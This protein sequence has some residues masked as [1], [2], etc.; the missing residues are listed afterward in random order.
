[1]L[2]LVLAVLATPQFYGPSALQPY[3]R[4]SPD[5]H[6][7]L[8]V[9]PTARDGSGP[10]RYRCT[11]D[12][13][14]AWA[15][16]RP[17]SFWDSLV[18]DD[19]FVAGYSYSGRG[20]GKFGQGELHAVVLA[21]DGTRK[22]DE[23]HPLEYGRFV[24]R[25]LDPRAVGLFFQADLKLMVFRIADREGTEEWWAFRLPEARSEFRRQPRESLP[26][27]ALAGRVIAARGLAN[28][29][30][31]LVAW[32]TRDWPKLGLQF[33]LLGSGLELLWS[34]EHPTELQE[35]SDPCADDRF[36]SAV[37][38]HGMLFEEKETGRF[39]I[40]L[41]KSGL[42]IRYVV[43]RGS[44]NPSVH[45]IGREPWS[46]PPKRKPA[47]RFMDL[48]VTDLV[49]R[50]TTPLAVGRKEAST[51]AE[52]ES[53]AK[54]D[55]LGKPSALA[56]DMFGRVL[57]QDASTGTVHV[58]DGKGR[59][60]LVCRLNPEELEEGIDGWG[61]V[62][63]REGGVVVPT[64]FD[65]PFIRFDPDGTRQESWKPEDPVHQ[66]LFSPVTDDA[67]AQGYGG[68]F[69]R[70]GPNH[71]CRGRFD[72]SPEGTWLD[73]GGELGVGPDGAVA[74]TEPIR[75]EGPGSAS[76]IVLFETGDPSSGR[77]FPVP[78]GTPAFRLALGRSW[79]A[80]SGDQGEVLLI[81]RADGEFLRLSDL[82]AI[83]RPG[84]SYGFD[85][86]TDELIAAGGFPLRIRRFALP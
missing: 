43:E 71:G 41:P 45:E 74:V 26:K 53:P 75:D 15:G 28:S 57:V 34:D 13:K 29:P 47:L 61:L 40:G 84:W 16:E 49:D 77:S 5:G 52:G 22:L 80:S 30:F 70:L 65:K 38:Q 81:R 39:A 33:T 19:G 37:E 18:T 50:G 69:D 68:G 24:D 25:V 42:K 21:P 63:T 64:G 83:R 27:N 1:M 10:A 9:D 54:D 44:G 76:S 17:W 56:I 23:S 20:L 6:W 3:R 8:S 4:S 62:A 36:L 72:R 2:A 66:L 59:Q 58:F 31:T 11:H 12:G 73:L 14:D 79:M 55:V 35:S 78:S 32:R 67:F 86:A 48:P 51:S 46:L 7:E 82:E 85:P 60:L